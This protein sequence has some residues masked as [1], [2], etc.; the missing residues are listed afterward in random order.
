MMENVISKR[1]HRL[2]QVL[3]RRPPNLTLLTEDVHKPHNLSVII[4]TCDA[5][6]I[7][8]V[9]SVNVTGELPTFFQVSQ[10]SEK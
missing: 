9:H 3:K 10:G 2:K 6:G 5:V 7:F 1:H 8:E 4:R